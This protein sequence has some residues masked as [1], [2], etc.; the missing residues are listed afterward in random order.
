MLGQMHYIQETTM[1]ALLPLL[2][3]AAISSYALPIQ[4]SAGQD[5]KD[6]GNSTKDASKKVYGKRKRGFKKGV[7]KTASATA[8]G[9]NKVKDKTAGE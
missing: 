3:L 2:A 4:Q 7:H 5:M 1:K 6:A 9:A 8:H